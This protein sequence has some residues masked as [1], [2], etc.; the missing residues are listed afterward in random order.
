MEQRCH[1][2]RPSDA[3][4]DAACL[5]NQGTWTLHN[6]EHASQG[7]WPTRRSPRGAGQV[8]GPVQAD[9]PPQLRASDAPRSHS[10][11]RPL[12]THLTTMLAVEKELLL[13]ETAKNVARLR[14]SELR[15]YVEHI[16]GVQTMAT[17]LAGFAFTAFIAM[18]PLA[19][20]TSAVLLMQPSGDYVY[21][22]STGSVAKAP[23]ERPDP[24]QI[25]AFVMTC[26]QAL[27]VVLC[28]GEMMHVMT[29]TLVARQLGS[30]LALRGQ[31]GSIIIATRR[32][33]ASLAN[34]TKRFFGGL[35]SF[36]LS[37]V[38]HALRGMHPGLALVVAVVILWY[39]KMQG[40]LV[41]R[42]AKDFELRRAVNT[43]FPDGSFGAERSA[44]EGGASAS[45]AEEDSHPIAHH[46]SLI[47]R[48]RRFVGK[49]APAEL[50]DLIGPV[51]HQ[52]K[53][54][55]QQVDDVEGDPHDPGAHTQCPHLRLPLCA[56]LTGGVC[57]RLC[58][59]RRCACALCR[60]AWR[61]GGTAHRGDEDTHQ[62]RRARSAAQR[63]LQSRCR[64][65]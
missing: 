22:D 18:E 36:L 25:F 23:D 35:Q 6:P 57:A 39:L 30:R 31:D 63:R 53:I 9:A 14:E 59:V 61:A 64:R 43:V 19:L 40:A 12:A 49:L 52:L 55:Y 29:E 11:N 10:S 17:L 24:F 42:L 7:T 48:M 54:L 3:M 34:A 65:R 37:V 38:F 1:G 45:A 16:G 15:Y 50:R 26:I 4:S 56:L 5:L 28:L 62:P 20:K 51:N 46:Q 27:L 8:P 47:S 2:W 13:T 33:A 41:K 44:D 32:L 58:T 60:R 21:N